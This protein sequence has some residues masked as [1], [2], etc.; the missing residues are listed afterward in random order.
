MSADKL[1][2][3]IVWLVILAATAAV[4]WHVWWSRREP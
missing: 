3:L 2:A 1:A 4:V